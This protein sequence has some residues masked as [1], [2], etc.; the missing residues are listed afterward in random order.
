MHPSECDAL[1]AEDEQDYRDR[2]G[3]YAPAGQ[4]A[5]D[6]R[7]DR[8]NLIDLDTGDEYEWIGS[9]GY[10]HEGDHDFAWPREDLMHSGNRL[11]DVDSLEPA[12]L[13]ERRDQ[14]AAGDVD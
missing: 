1:R 2:T 14:Y 5:S 4:P 7:A 12:R 6:P 11:V 13:A 9:E 8:P 3:P 10:A